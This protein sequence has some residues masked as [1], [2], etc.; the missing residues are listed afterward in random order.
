VNAITFY[1]VGNWAYRKRIPVVPKVWYRLTYL[2]YNCSIEPSAEIG[3]GS[4]CTH[5][6]VAVV[7]H[8]R[9]KIGRNVEIAQGVTIGGRGKTVDD[10]GPPR[11]GAPTIEDNV[12][13]GPGACVLGPIHVGEGAIIGANAVVIK[14]VPA[15]AV[16]GGVPAKILKF[17]DGRFKSD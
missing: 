6:G 8:A 9:A 5:I 12:Y 3:E 17:T 1:R 13:I 15:R 11:V 10:G 7:I 2:I 16:V 14:D 4:T